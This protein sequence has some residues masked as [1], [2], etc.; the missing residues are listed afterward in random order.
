MIRGDPAGCPGGAK[1]PEPVLTPA[2]APQLPAPV[3]PARSL[4]HVDPTR[5]F[6]VGG[7]GPAVPPVL[8]ASSASADAS[9][10]TN[11]S[12]SAGSLETAAASKVPTAAPAICAKPSRDAATPALLPNGDSAAALDSGLAMPNPSRKMAAVAKNSGSDSFATRTAARSA[13]PPVAASPSPTSVA[14]YRP[15]RCRQFRR[16][17]SPA[18]HHEH[19]AGKQPSERDGRQSKALE[20]HARC[21][22]ENG[23]QADH[24]KGG[25]PG[26]SQE[27]GVPDQVEIAKSDH[28]WIDRRAGG[29]IGFAYQRNIPSDRSH[30]E[31][32]DK[33]K[34]RSPAE[35]MIEHA[36]EQRRKAQRRRRRNGDHGHDFREHLSIEQVPRDRARQHRCRT[37]PGS[38]DRP[39]DQQAWEI[40]GERTPDRAGDEN[41]K[42][43]QI[44]RPSAEP[45]RQRTDDQLPCART[46]R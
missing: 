12:P 25:R 33:D 29:P 24:Q 36:A 41:A 30:R 16:Q 34:R 21:A 37:C 38:L 45:V 2:Y 1:P 13:M 3:P 31:N 43:D 23:E 6:M 19:D 11:P 7:V 28:K 9:A 15:R 5:R 46:A 40:A 26:G 27:S 10:S 17:P 32:S 18:E 42:P 14:R 44:H 22:R 4:S 39:A 35:E 8:P 20:Q